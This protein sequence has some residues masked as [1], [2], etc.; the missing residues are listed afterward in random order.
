[1]RRGARS[2]AEG[3]NQSEEEKLTKGNKTMRKIQTREST[4]KSPVG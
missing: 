2:Q 3:I 4:V 1:M